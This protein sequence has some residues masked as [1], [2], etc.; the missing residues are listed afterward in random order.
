MNDKAEQS[1]RSPFTLFSNEERVLDNAEQMLRSLES[2]GEGVQA[3]AQAYRRSY[4]EQRRLLRLSDRVQA[5]LHQANQRLSEKTRDLEALNARLNEVNEQKDLL[6]RIIAHDLRN[7][8]S[9]V[10]GYTQYLYHRAPHLDAATVQDMAGRAHEATLAVTRLLDTLLEWSRLQSGEVRGKFQPLTLVELAEE[11]LSLYANLARRKEITLAVDVHEAL[12]A[13]GDQDMVLTIL[14]NLVNNAIKFTPPGGRVVLR[15]R[16]AAPV[17][18]QVAIEVADTGTGIAPEELDH[19]FV[20][21]TGR[22]RQSGTQGEPGLG[23]GLPICKQLAE[24]QG[25]QLQVHSEPGQGTTFAL[26]LDDATG[27]AGSAVPSA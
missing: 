14:R 27:E 7:P 13:R 6:F 19:L 20:P 26:I 11:V 18:G 17:P 10:S 3:L 12:Q 22:E 16:A 2:V 4:D 5:D 25:G 1:G 9:V 23:L 15:A 21:D 24:R 8:F